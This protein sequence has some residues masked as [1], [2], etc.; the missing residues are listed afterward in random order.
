M[1]G[2]RCTQFSHNSQSVWG[3]CTRMG[4]EVG[5]CTRTGGEVGGGHTCQVSS[6]N[7]E[8]PGSDLQ[9]KILWLLRG[10]R[11]MKVGTERRPWERPRRG[12][13]SVCLWGKEGWH[14]QECGRRAWVAP[15]V[16][17]VSSRG[18]G[19]RTGAGRGTSRCDAPSLSLSLLLFSFHSSPTSTQ[20]TLAC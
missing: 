10:E 8:Q 19:R 1:G 20:E 12:R 11:L 13:T 18:D 4:G 2:W 5:T 17:G 6:E 14:V 15:Q 9:E 3:T 7:V 16:W